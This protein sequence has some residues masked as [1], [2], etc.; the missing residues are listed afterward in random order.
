[1]LVFSAL[2][3]LTIS[4]L[5]GCAPKKADTAPKMAG[6][7]T[8]SVVIQSVRVGDVTQTVPVTGSLVAL[9]DVSLSAKQG[10]R[11]AEISVREGDKV[12]AGQILARVDA[13]DLV[14]QMHADEA[15]VSSAQAKVEQAEAAYRQQ[16]A[17][18]A[19][20]IASARA[21]YDQQVA[22][23]SANV[24]SAQSALNSAKSN[25]STVQEGARPEERI[26][27]QAALASAEANFKKAQADVTR[28]GKLHD[29]GAV[30]EAEMDQYRNTLDVAQ[31]NLN[32]AKAALQLQQ[33]GNRR[34]D[35]EQAQ[36]KVRQAEES[37]RT[38]QAARSTDAVKKADLE[39]AIA[40][41]A[42]DS[43]KLADVQAAKAALQ[44]AQNTLTIAR[45][46]VADTVVRAPI[47]GRISARSAEPGMIIKSDTIL[48]HLITLDSVYF[49]PSV[50]DTTMGKIRV[51]Q[52]VDVRID[53]YPGQIFAGTITKIYPQGSSTSRSVPLRVT[54][55]NT[56]GMLRPNM[57]AQ[58]AIV[59]DRHDGVVLAPRAA[60]IQTTDASGNLTGKT[61]LFSVED[62]VAHEH[63]VT[64]G[65]STDKGDW[66][67]VKGIP[68]KSEVVILG[69]NGL[70]DGQKVVTTV[71][72]QSADDSTK[73]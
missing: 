30:S 9:Q 6:P 33:Q 41:K 62:D 5:S 7:T 14:S 32:S 8:V 63:M 23:S 73:Q 64:P 52:R 4:G 65:L 47:A 69:Q 66:I 46:A 54:L 68:R 25:L 58:G 22:T 35:V 21:A 39:T 36:E 44:Q 38:A 59:T 12:S 49:E 51:G 3:A 13:T 57:F 18:T 43:V 10:G 15:G 67:E 56:Q 19:S 2:L 71:S 48:L 34:Q 37:L 61:A 11:L 1:M 70:K 20:G 27:T 26:Q 50:P 28:Y 60:L 42:Q 17:N 53:T 16:V 40:Q 72:A 55:Q 24:R 29:A 31:A 45:Q